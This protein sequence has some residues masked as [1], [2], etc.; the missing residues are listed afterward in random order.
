MTLIFF[1]H[2]KAARLDVRNLKDGSMANGVLH[3][4]TEV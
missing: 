3:P 1:P 4:V 2:Y